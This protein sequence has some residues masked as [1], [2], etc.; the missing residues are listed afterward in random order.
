M[1]ADPSSS[2]FAFSIRVDEE[3]NV[4][5]LTQIGVAEKDDQ[6]RMFAEYERALDKVR[7][8]WV[9]LVDQG[10][11]RGFSDEAL[12]IG[13]QMVVRTAERGVGH[14]IRVKPRQPAM[15]VRITRVLITA[16][17]TYETEL[18]DTLEGAEAAVSVYLAAHQN[19][20]G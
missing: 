6:L 4:L 1:A 12:E 17:A 19:K 15:R 7:P 13:A 10:E 3:R 9:L 18:V 8:G 20:S 16:R 5:Y 2:G 11:V 14:V